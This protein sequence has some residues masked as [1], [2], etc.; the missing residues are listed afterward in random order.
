MPEYYTQ[1]TYAPS[2][3]E[4]RKDEIRARVYEDMLQRGVPV[5]ASHKYIA[6]IIGLMTYVYDAVEALPDPP[7]EKERV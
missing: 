2:P 4:K 1:T 6:E 5:T 3:V 7:E